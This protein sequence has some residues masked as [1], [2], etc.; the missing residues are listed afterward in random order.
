MINNLTIQH[1]KSIR[2]LTLPCRRVNVLIGEPNTGKTNILEAL[3]LLSPHTIRQ[4]P[5]TL[6]VSLPV[7]LFWDQN[8]SQAIMVGA[9]G[10]QI[11]ITPQENGLLGVQRR[12][13][14][15]GRTQ[16]F[17]LDENWDC[18]QTLGSPVIE[19]VRYF[20]FD[21]SS[22]HNSGESAIL[23]PPFGQNIA[24]LLYASKE[25]RKSSAGFFQ[26]SGFRLNVDFT[27][28][29]L[30]LSKEVDDT[31]ISFPY[32]STSETLRRMVFY[33]LAV[34]TG[35]GQILVFDEPEAHSF[36]PF[37][38]NF[39]ERIALDDRGTQY[40]LTTHSPYMLD[41]LLA[42]TPAGDLNIVLCR[43]ENF[44]TKA[45][46]LNDAQKA[47]LMEWS[48]DSFFNFDRLLEEA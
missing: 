27:H 20:L 14:E 37:T 17:I 15:S 32:S 24:N 31:L 44:E 35:G 33:H 9:S 1:F 18:G 8:L 2:D 12:A 16:Y 19:G 4:I 10:G 47:K 23:E 7:D 43:M 3:A 48:M 22:P 41:S 28:R 30:L 5:G 34:E 45:Y 40:F 36:P 6:R 46:P 29:R 38:K 26:K 13:T 21:G 25:A 39:A 42:K 11:W